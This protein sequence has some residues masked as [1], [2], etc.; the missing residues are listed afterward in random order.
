MLDWKNALPPNSGVIESPEVL[1]RGEWKPAPD[2]LTPEGFAF[3][4]RLWHAGPG[5]AVDVRGLEVICRSTRL[6][7]PL[8]NYRTRTVEWVENRRLPLVDLGTD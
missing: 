4:N 1:D 8:S 6:F 2:G 3:L 5:G 7:S